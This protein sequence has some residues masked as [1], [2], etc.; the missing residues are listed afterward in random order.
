MD[1]QQAARGQVGIRMV[2]RLRG[3][4]KQRRQAAGGN[5]NV[6]AEGSLF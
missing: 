4:G 5:Q 3:L 1:Q 2:D 6:D